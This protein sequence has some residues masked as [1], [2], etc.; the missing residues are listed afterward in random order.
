MEGVQLPQ[1]V[2]VFVNIIVQTVVCLFLQLSYVWEASSWEAK[3]Q[4]AFHQGQYNSEPWK[5]ES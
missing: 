4:F 1:L 3:Q 2:C 5:T